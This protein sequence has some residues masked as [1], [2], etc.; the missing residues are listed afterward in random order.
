MG[1]HFYAEPRSVPGL[2]QGTSTR[3]T[4]IE[5]YYERAPG[6]VVHLYGILAADGP[7]GTFLNLNTDND[8]V[9][10]TTVGHLEGGRGGGGG[11][12]GKTADLC[13]AGKP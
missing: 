2:R 11:G 6:E 9:V 12:D 13:K 7:R 3:T 10:A 8:Q 5:V 4:Q 1:P